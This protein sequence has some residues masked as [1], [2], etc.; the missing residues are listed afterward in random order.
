MSIF[1]HSL[2]RDQTLYTVVPLALD[3]NYTQSYFPY[4]DNPFGD[5]QLLSTQELPCNWF[6]YTNKKYSILLDEVNKNEA[7]YKKQGGKNKTNKFKVPFT[8]LLVGQSNACSEVLEHYNTWAV[9]DKD[10][11]VIP[12]TNKQE[13]TVQSQNN[14]CWLPIQHP[15]IW[16]QA[17]FSDVDVT[18]LYPKLLEKELCRIFN[19]PIA[20]TPVNPL[21]IDRH[22]EFAA[23]LASIYALVASR[24]LYRTVL[25][26][27]HMWMHQMQF[28]CNAYKQIDYI[29]QSW[30]KLV[31]VPS[32]LSNEPKLK[33]DVSLA[34]VRELSHYDIRKE[35]YKQKNSLMARIIGLGFSQST[36]INKHNLKAIL[37][38][39]DVKLSIE[40]NNH[41]AKI[42]TPIMPNSRTDLAMKELVSYKL[43]IPLN[44]ISIVTINNKMYSSIK[45]REYYPILTNLVMFAIKNLT[46]K[47]TLSTKHVRLPQCK[48]IFKQPISSSVVFE[49]NINKYTKELALFKTTIIVN[50]GYISNERRTTGYIEDIFFSSFFSLCGYH[51]NI[52]DKFS[53]KI[54]FTNKDE[55]SYIAPYSKI[56]QDAVM[57]AITDAI[58]GYNQTKC[59]PTKRII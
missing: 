20:V 4:L 46:P 24:N 40:Y 58:S 56:V 45:S 47:K 36:V 52:G 2:D 53:L 48:S 3:M 13:E 28:F 30:Q 38:E 8:T 11:C 34:R 54:E 33:K 5:C 23:W 50:C 10:S 35:T 16:A 27:S 42:I 15:M 21:P 25:C 37:E 12:S 1:P 39:E 26:H 41:K 7:P 59:F 19:F 31:S 32:M 57:L 44:K 14:V 29:P 9:V 49:S 43:K 6:S 55:F 51:Q 22:N 18:T 17:T